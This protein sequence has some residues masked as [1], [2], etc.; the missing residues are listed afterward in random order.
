MSND[1]YI[2]A[3]CK[4]IEPFQ[5]APVPARLAVG[6]KIASIGHCGFDDGHGCFWPLD[7][8]NLDTYPTD[9]GYLIIT[10]TKKSTRLTNF[11]RCSAGSPHY[12]FS[13]Q[14]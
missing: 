2:S 5:Q 11:R 12:H 1:D 13:F 9:G 4:A 6:D 8:A 7:G 10:E 3:V 14:V